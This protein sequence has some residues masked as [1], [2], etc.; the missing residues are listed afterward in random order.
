MRF[1]ADD[2]WRTLFDVVLLQAIDLNCRMICRR[3]K[4]MPLMQ[5]SRVNIRTRIDNKS[6]TA[7]RNFHAQRV[8][9]AVRAATV[10][11][12]ATR[13]EEQVQVTI[14]KNVRAA[15]GKGLGT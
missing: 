7:G 4:K 3:A 9:V 12:A 13:I 6:G 8:V 15:L 1:I 14:A 2:K 11:S 5:V 10:D